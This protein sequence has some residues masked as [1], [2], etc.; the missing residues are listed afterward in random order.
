MQ[1]DIP[2]EVKG[3]IGYVPQEVALYPTMSIRENL[4]FMGR[5]YGLKGKKLEAED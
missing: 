3:F 2:Q 1:S 4:R 5:I